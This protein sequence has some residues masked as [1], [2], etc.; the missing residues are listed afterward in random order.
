M[1]KKS[2]LGS[3]FDDTIFDD[4][5]LF[6]AEESIAPQK[7][8][9]TDIE[10]NKKQP[11]KTFN[12]EALNALAESILE[13]GVIQPLTVRPYGDSY[14]IVAGE[15]RWRAA[16]IAGL[17]EVPVRIM[18]LSDEQTMQ[19]ALIENLQR[20]DLNP[21]EEALGYQQLIDTF[22]MKQEEVAK[23]VGKA[24]SSITNSLR[25]LTLPDDIKLMVR[26]G[27]LSVGHCKVII[28]I[29]DEEKQRLLAER[30]VKEGLSVRTLEKLAKQAADK[31]AREKPKKETFLVEAEISMTDYI[32]KPVRIDKSKDKYTMSID[33]K[34]EEE[35]K[36][37]ISFISEKR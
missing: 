7:L 26:D 33:C 15:R 4:D 14:Q 3:N 37:L 25:L 19:I 22:D 20:E 32:G 31:P 6:G 16:K 35:L 23:K 30:S 5:G 1:A 10:P 18:E 12:E 34:S 24:R 17:K 29:P 28:G 13:H 2:G 11:R 8:K 27:E 21:I 36:E 9:I